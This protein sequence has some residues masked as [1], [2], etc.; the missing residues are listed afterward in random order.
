[1]CADRAT[2]IE[3][4]VRLYTLSPITKRI[5]TLDVTTERLKMWCA[6]KLAMKIRDVSRREVEIGIR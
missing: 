3:E 1:M 6:L 4:D 2:W 5:T